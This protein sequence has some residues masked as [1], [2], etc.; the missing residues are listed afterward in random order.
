MP[1]WTDPVT[2]QQ[3]IDTHHLLTNYM[4]NCKS[5]WSQTWHLVGK[6]CKSVFWRKFPH[7][8]PNIWFYEGEIHWFRFHEFD[9]S[10]WDDGWQLQWQ[11]SRIG[12]NTMGFARRKYKSCLAIGWGCEATRMN[13][14]ITC[15]EGVLSIITST[16]LQF[17]GDNPTSNA[18]KQDWTLSADEVASSKLPKIVTAA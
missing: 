3:M 18:S 6:W 4:G 9:N 1:R 2:G 12:L 5:I 15:K 14:T 16:S 11:T 7:C 10:V 17:M 8:R 13:F